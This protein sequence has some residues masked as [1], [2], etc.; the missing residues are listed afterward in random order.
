[1]SVT[2]MNATVATGKGSVR[3]GARWARGAMLALGVAFAPVISHAETLSD[4]MVLAYKNSGLLAQNRA[5]LR[6]ADENVAQ[7][8]A[9]LRPVVSYLAGTTHNFDTATWSSSLTLS[10]DLT[11]YDFGRS[12]LAVDVA[13]ESVLAM[14][15]RL[16]GY[17]QTVLNNTVAAYLGVRS[18]QA[19]VGLRASNVRLITQELRAA[20]D[21][22][23]VGEVTRTDVSLV[24]AQLAAARAAAAQAQ[25]DLNVAR[26]S[27]KAATGQYPGNL[28]APPSPPKTANSLEGARAIARKR[29]PNILAAQRDVTGAELS[30]QRSKAAVYPSLSASASVRMVD[31]VAPGAQ[32]TTETFGLN[33]S[34]PIYQ[35]GA[36]KSLQR[37][38]AAQRDASRAALLQAV[39]AVEQGVGNAWSQVSV[40]NASLQATQQQVCA[41]REAFEG[42]RQEA[43]LGA[44]T[45]LD[46]LDAEQDLLD[47]QV[48]AISAEIGRYQAVYSLLSSMGL[49]TTEH[50]NLGVPRYDPTGYYNAV[51]NAPLVDVSP[52]GAKLDRVLQSIGKN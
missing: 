5:L 46:V 48:S 39:Q 19:V 7:S 13:K 28:A 29:H 11:L 44:R 49:L 42:V 45:T 22:F 4:A 27:Y 36:L 41:A 26:E 38:A 35:G 20:R 24:E 37:Q 8:V 32:S 3:R 30:I 16:I 15:D 33:L 9:A 21:R 1:M 10:A 2:P 25:G 18:A 34:G 40:S 52:Q 43:N 23:E 17:E 12:Q 6:A 47:A 14:R 31:P 51:K 50:L